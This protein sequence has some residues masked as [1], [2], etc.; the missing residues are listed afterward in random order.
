MVIVADG[1]PGAARRLQR[2]L[3]SDPGMGIVRHADAGYPEAIQAGESQGRPNSNA[4]GVLAWCA[5]AEFF[6]FWSASP[7][8]LALGADLRLGN[9]S[10]RLS[11]CSPTSLR[12]DYQVDLIPWWR[13]LT[14]KSRIPPG[15]VQR[16][17]N[18][19]DPP[20]V[21]LVQQAIID[22][23]T[24]GY[25]RSDIESLAQLAQALQSYAP[26]WGHSHE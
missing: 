18:L 2:V 10:A 5:P 16:L 15:T 11:G 26:R 22:A 1:T 14:R 9:S 6:G 19:Q 4:W 21:C 24:L 23:Q 20:T 12:K 13:R 17:D 25:P 8:V 7:W 3:T